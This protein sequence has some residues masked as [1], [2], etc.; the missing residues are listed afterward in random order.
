[1]PASTERS[2]AVSNAPARISTPSRTRSKLAAAFGSAA[3]V[4]VV[5]TVSLL[6]IQASRHSLE[7]LTH[8]Y[9][10]RSEIRDLRQALVDAETGQRGYIL[11]G[12]AAYLAPYERGR[13]HFR[14]HLAELRRL[15]P[16]NVE[17][18]EH[19]EAL[20][21]LKLAELAKTISV[22]ELA[23][24][25][26]AIDIVRTDR[27]ESVM[28]ELRSLFAAMEAQEDEV[29]SERAA[30]YEMWLRIT[31][32][33]VGGGAILA[34]AL[35][36]LVN[37]G[38]RKEIAER[39]HSI[40]T[41]A[42]Q[43]EKLRAQAQILAANEV[44]LAH[45][46][47]EEQSLTEELRTTN[48]VL[49]ARVRDV[50]FANAAKDRLVI[51]LAKSNSDL[52][53]FAYVASHDLKAPL[54]GIANLSEWIEEDLA[55]AMTDKVREQLRLL[56]GRVHRMEGLIDGILE[57]S[58]AGRA[59]DADES[60]DTRELLDDTLELM[61]PPPGVSIRITPELP[62]VVAP[63]IFLQQIFI[64]LVGNALKHARHDAAEVEIGATD[65]GTNWEFFVR[66]NGPGIDPKFHDRIFGIFQTLA[67]RDKVEGTGIGLAVVKKLVESRGGR[68]WVES[69]LGSGATFKF[70]LPKTLSTSKETSHD[71]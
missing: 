17:T 20:G 64:N 27:G 54:R 26:A 19:V 42:D 29:L 46:L 57:Y 18:L 28:A 55:D 50:A 32:G 4:L 23:G 58:R 2:R 51:Q 8:A 15:S 5:A 25:D 62:T 24:A 34:F 12:E 33:V 10:V 47:E 36:V 35:A 68:I 52:D 31:T 60:L 22:R 13:A 30:E 21:D 63:K 6:S 56:R 11:S 9:A 66:D 39:E 69:T 37:L 67:S 44:R 71:Q 7:R 41:I 70:T 3:L 49:D 53:Q 40:G 38:I 59:R 16:R 14:E 43:A 48:E 45:Q 1:M 65:G 61:A